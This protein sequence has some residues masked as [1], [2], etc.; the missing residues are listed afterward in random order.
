MLQCVMGMVD[1]T[2]RAVAVL[3]QRAQADRDE[4]IGWAKQQV[5]N[6]ELEV[7]RKAGE[8]MAKAMKQG[9]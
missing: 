9:T 5:N 6:A 8:V 2:K 3:Q 1:R 7:K 4:V